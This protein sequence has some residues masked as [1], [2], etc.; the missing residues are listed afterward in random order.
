MFMS[1]EG[2]AQTVLQKPR[3]CSHTYRKF[4]SCCD[5]ASKMEIKDAWFNLRVPRLELRPKLPGNSFK[6]GSGSLIL[7][8][9]PH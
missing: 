4:R 2:Q 6:V 7:L 3:C 9:L 1:K 8:V 5:A